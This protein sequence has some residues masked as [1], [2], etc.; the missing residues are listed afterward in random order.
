MDPSGY[1]FCSR[2]CLFG[3]KLSCCLLGGI[4]CREFGFASSG[5]IGCGAT[6]RPAV[7]DCSSTAPGTPVSVGVG[8]GEL[9]ARFPSFL[10]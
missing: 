3:G 9:P 5:E 7:G 4:F 6:L 10:T 2:C 8:E 1:E